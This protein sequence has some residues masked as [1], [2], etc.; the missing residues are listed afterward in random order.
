MR[1]AEEG[2]RGQ[3]H[4]AVQQYAE[5][6]LRERHRLLRYACGQLH[7]GEDAEQVLSNVLQKVG[8][9]LVSGRVL[10]TA[11]EM[12]AYTL[13]SISNEATSRM[14]SAERR[15][16][17]ESLYVCSG[18]D[19]SEDNEEEAAAVRWAILQ[20][21]P[22]FARLITLHLWEDMSFAA[23]AELL[24]VPAGTLRDRY[25]KALAQLEQVLK[26]NDLP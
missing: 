3:A 9:A 23:M 7:G 22:E 6:F 24:H 26:D 8:R 16:K 15:R 5:W 2:K 13:R 19:G 21:P 14:R 25:N 20:L 12:E 4:P 11:E 1:N 17:T 18:V 10:L